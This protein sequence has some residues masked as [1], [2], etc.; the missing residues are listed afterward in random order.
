MIQILPV[1]A[2][3]TG[4]GDV[5]GDDITNIECRCNK[6]LA[7]TVGDVRVRRVEGTGESFAQ[8]MWVVDTG[9]SVTMVNME[10]SG[11]RLTF[12]QGDY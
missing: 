7:F 11:A 12:E 2:H 8:D 5:M 4:W 3:I 9:M 10:W 6:V 1:I